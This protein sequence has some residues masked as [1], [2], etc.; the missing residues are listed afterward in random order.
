MYVIGS[1][2][3]TL[4]HKTKVMLFGSP[5]MLNKVPQFEIMLNNVPLQNVVSYK[6]L[7][8]SLDNQ[9]TYNLHVNKLIVSVMAKLKQFRR[10]RGF[11]H[12]KATLMVYT[13]ML[14]PILE[15]CDIFLSATSSI[16]LRDCKGTSP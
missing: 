14:L 11:L 3:L 2:S 9:L 7:G 5:T 6:Y 1:R 12:A 16:F 13:N 10:M 8:V 4:G 15:Y